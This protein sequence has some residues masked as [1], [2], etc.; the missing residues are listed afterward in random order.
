M[1]DRIRAVF[2]AATGVPTSTFSF[3]RPEVAC[4]ECDGMGSVEVWLRFLP[5]EWVGCGTCGGRRFADEVPAV[6]ARP[7]DGVE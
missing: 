2:A 3:D 1:A 7:A 6:R 5:S 4:A